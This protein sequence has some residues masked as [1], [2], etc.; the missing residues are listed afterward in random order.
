MEKKFQKKA[1]TLIEMLIVIVIIWVLAAALIPRLTSVR[2]RAND[3]A[4]KADLNQIATAI[5]ARQMDH[6]GNLPSTSGWTLNAWD[7]SADLIQAWLDSVPQ[8]PKTVTVVT[9]LSWV[10]DQTAAWQYWYMKVQKNGISNS[11]F[12]VMAKME[13]PGAS[14]RLYSW[15]SAVISG[16]MIAP[17]QETANLTPC[18]TVTKASAGSG[19]ALNPG[20]D[21]YFDNYDQLRFMIV[22]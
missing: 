5:I 12:I 10:S 14:N 6:N 17:T 19:F 4:R 3:V 20:W 8:D 7:L 13:T 18:K 22:R 9:W 11:A 2:D 16:W 21:C 1:F 15:G